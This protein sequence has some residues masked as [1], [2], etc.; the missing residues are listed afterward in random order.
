MMGFVNKCWQQVADGG[1]GHGVNEPLV[2]GMGIQ[3]NIHRLIQVILSL[4]GA[5]FVNLPFLW[6]T[7]MGYRAAFTGLSI[8]EPLSQGS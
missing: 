8:L 6:T 7:D 4:S 1:R 3:A 5:I 2:V